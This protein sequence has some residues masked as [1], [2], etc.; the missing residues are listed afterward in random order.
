MNEGGREGV[1]D[2]FDCVLALFGF[3][4]PD[5]FLHFEPISQL[6]EIYLISDARFPL[7]NLVPFRKLREMNL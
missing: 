1:N 6:K 4:G 5:T 7:K 2:I 3:L